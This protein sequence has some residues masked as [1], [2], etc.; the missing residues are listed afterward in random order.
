YVELTI[1]SEKIMA[2]LNIADKIRAC[3]AANVAELVLTK[4]FL[5]D[6]KGNLRTFSRQKFRCIACNEKFRRVPLLGKCTACGGKLVL[7][8]SEGAVRKYIEPSKQMMD[9]YQ[10]SLYIQQQFSLIESAADSLFG[11]KPRQLNLSNF[12]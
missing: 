4:H 6:I 8:V 11:K 1:M 9:R 2:Q 12:K 5:K 7:T 10:L 3:D